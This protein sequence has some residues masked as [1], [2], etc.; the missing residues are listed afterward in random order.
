MTIAIDDNLVSDFAAKDL[1]ANFDS[2]QAKEN[3]IRRFRLICLSVGVVDSDIPTD[4]NDYPTGD[5]VQ[6]LISNLYTYNIFR[7]NYGAAGQNQD[8]Y[9]AKMQEYKKEYKEIQSMLT[10]DVILNDNDSFP[11]S[12]WSTEAIGGLQ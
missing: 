5:M 6:E 10:A 1:V 2:S 4:S 9:Y 3:T 12:N 11:S 7:A 8:L